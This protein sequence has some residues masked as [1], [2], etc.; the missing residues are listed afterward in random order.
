M[1]QRKN[2][3]WACLLLLFVSCN[4][5]NEAENRTETKVV[6]IKVQ[7]VTH[8]ATE[9]RYSFI[10][11]PYKTVELSFRVSGPVK[12]FDTQS[13]KFY[14]KGEVIAAID[15]RDFII[16][17]NEMEAIYK[18][19]EAE[20]YRIANLYEKD[21]ISGSAYEKAK[22]EYAKAKAAYETATN[23]LEDTQLRAPFDGFVQDINIEQYQ[24]VKASV[25]AFSFIDLSRIK[26]ETYIPED[27]AEIFHK[28]KDLPCHVAFA[29]LKGKQYEATETFISQTVTANNISFLLTA[30]VEN[31]DNN[32]FGG[33]S[34]EISLP[35]PAAS[36]ITMVSVP[37][38]A[39]FHQTT[40]KASVWK[41][42]KENRVHCT[43]VELGDAY[44][45]NDIEIVSGLQAGDRIVASGLYTLSE[46]EQVS[47]L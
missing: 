24:E 25:P 36:D 14:R 18:Q 38:M 12:Q 30:I 34:G 32:L 39:I 8:Q 43:S 11:H 46:N 5:K 10:S 27:V 17:K 3:I 23:E 20:Y 42:D 28:K 47:N 44:D 29:G 26:I 13:G 35:I 37:Q 41:L 31:K 1:K 7:S 22:A 21:D 4:S 15:S 2:L 33:M 40:N 19:A 9:R 45:K 16:R 6:V